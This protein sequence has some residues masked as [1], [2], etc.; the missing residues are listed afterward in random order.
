VTTFW[1]RI[2]TVLLLFVLLAVIGALASRAWGGPLDPP[3]PPASSPGGID[4]RVPLSQAG[5]CP[6]FISS[7]GSYYLTSDIQVPALPVNAVVI[8]ASDVTLDLNGFAID[9]GNFGNGIVASG[10]V[11]RITIRNGS[12][13]RGFNRGID[14]ASATQ[15]V[16]QDLNVMQNGAGTAIVAGEAATLRDVATWATVGSGISLGPVADVQGCTVD[17]FGNVG[18]TGLQVGV[19][20]SVSHCSVAYFA[21]GISA[22]GISRVSDC[23]VRF[24]PTG[25]SIGDTATVERCTVDSSNSGILAGVATRVS[26]CDVRNSSLGVSVNVGSTVERCTIG[27]MAGTGAAGIYL[28]GNGVAEDNEVDTVTGAGSCGI[29]AGGS[30]NRVDGNH[31]INSSNG[32]CVRGGSSVF[33]NTLWNNASGGIVI[34]AGINDVGPIG[35]AA[36]ATS[37]WANISY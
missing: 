28:N 29:Y 10:S 6:I 35:T 16:L 23:V 24:A 27:S 33:R 26:D 30:G 1:N 8:T 17:G 13:S 31:A 34:L 37:P 36:A 7:P 9:A 11:T 2:N 12:V 22:G 32:I 4:G 15:S 5:C 21:T 25:V 20:S 14:L 19:H 18:G 3:G